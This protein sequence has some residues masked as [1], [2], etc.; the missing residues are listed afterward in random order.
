MK[1]E[2]LIWQNAFNGGEFDFTSG[3]GW[4]DRWRKGRECYGLR[5]L[6]A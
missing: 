1:E 5:K 4:I 3:T 6:N 2:E